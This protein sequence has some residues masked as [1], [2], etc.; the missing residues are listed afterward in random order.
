MSIAI[1]GAG[2]G[3]LTTA[4]FLEKLGIPVHI[5]EQSSKIKPVGAGIILAHNAMQVFDKLGFKEPISKL[6]KPLTSVNIKTTKLQAINTIEMQHFDDKYAVK[7]IAIQRG[8]LQQFLIN[9]LQTK[10][11]HLNK[12]VVDVKVDCQTSLLFSDGDAIEFDAVIGADGIHSIVRGTLFKGGVIRK[13]NQMCWRGI[14]NTKLPLQFKN[15]LN[16]LW[17]RGSRFGFVELSTNEIYWYGLHSSDQKL[18]KNDLI[19]YFNDYDPIV[20]K[21]LSQTSFDKL[22]KNEIIDLKPISTW[23]KNSVCLLGDAAHATTPNMGQGACQAIEDAYVISHYLSRYPANIAFSKYEQLR[24][25]KAD[26]VVNLSW[27]FG[28]LSQ[29]RNPFVTAVRNFFMRS[30]PNKYNIRQ[31]EKLYRLP[32]L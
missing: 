16:E 28:Y 14:S 26:M 25:S 4:L 30:I 32:K 8:I 9:Q 10:F 6:G 5:F 21:I 15:Q 29:I 31:S 7:S 27:R 13:P 18:E 1:V 23:Y 3:G 24:K 2:I 17:G 11:I 20:D 12:R 19:D 22:F